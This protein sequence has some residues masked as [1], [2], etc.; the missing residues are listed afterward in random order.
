MTD[1]G[2]NVR[3]TNAV[4]QVLEE[5]GIKYVL[6]IPGGHVGGLFSS[7]Y[8]HPTIRTVLVRE[9]SIGTAMAEAYGRRT[10]EPVAVIAQGEWIVG[11]AGQ[12]LIEALLG[13]SPILVLTDMTDAGPLSHH[14]PYQDG[15]ANYGSWDTRQALRAVCKRVLVSDYPEQSV[16]LTQLGIK[17]ALTG[18]QGPVAVVFRRDSLVGTIDPERKPRLHHTGNYLPRAPQAIDPAAIATATELIAKAQRP[19]VLAGNGVRLAQARGALASFAAAID[20]PLITTSSGKGVVDETA[21][22]SGG[23]VGA[24]GWASANALLSGSDLIVAV[25]TKLGPVD[26][27]DEHPNLIDPSRQTLIQLDVEP[28][29]VGWTY[30]IDHVILGDAAL[31]L[32]ALCD[33]TGDTPARPESAEQRVSA[34]RSADPNRGAP[35]A[36][37]NDAGA[38]E[39]QFTIETLRSIIPNNSV[40][41]CDAGEN[42]LFMMQWF[43]SR[44]GGDYLQ[45]S[46]GGGMGYA[47]PAALGAKLANPEQPCVAVCGDGG[48]GMSL[49]SLMTAVQ[50]NLPI[51]V[52]VLNNQALGWVANGLGKRAIASHFAHF[53]HAAIATAIGCDGRHVTTE[54]ELRDAFAAIAT[55]DRPIVIDV[56]TTMTTSFKDLM[57]DF[58]SLERKTLGY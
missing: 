45:P 27:G 8:D 41:T 40:V 25:G 33:A 46:S 54:T 1:T 47:V 56:P 37:T 16:Q 9:E 29:N 49:H 58:S 10:G 34:A 21:A 48:F 32:A 51:A 7:L 53:D 26:T 28:L 18:E 2:S 20:A 50:E 4:I 13:A 24:F 19:I 30:P 22:T 39:P 3:V 17:H 44:D 36:S 23:V 57:S 6:G 55:T 52:I 5:A 11:N 12:G 15:T 31:S 42:R 38:F 43:E 14:G 35:T